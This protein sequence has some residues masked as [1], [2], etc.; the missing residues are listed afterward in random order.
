LAQRSRFDEGA[1]CEGIAMNR[2]CW[3]VLSVMVASV[4]TTCPTAVAVPP[5]QKMMPFKRIDA[6]PKK[7]YTLTADNGPWLIMAATFSGDKAR[8][9]A[10][11]LVY[12]LRSRYKLPAFTYEVIFDYTQSTE[13]RGVNRYGAPQKGKYAL[14]KKIDEFAVLAGEF[15][16]VDDPSAQKTLEKLKRAPID[17]MDLNKRQSEGKK[18]YRSLGY[19]RSVIDDAAAKA[20]SKKGDAA[21][22]RGPLARAFITSNPLM[23]KGYF[24]PQGLDKFVLALNEDFEFSLLKCPA[25]YTVKVA[26]FNGRVEIDQKKIKELMNGKDMK[27][28]LEQAAVMAHKLTLALRKKGFEAYEFH[29]RFSSIV[30]VG[31][32]DS[33]GT[34]R[35]DGKT[36]I[37]PA[38]Y[39]LILSFGADKQNLPGQPPGVGQAKTFDGVPC[40]SQPMMVHVPHRSI[41]ADYDRAKFSLR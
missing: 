38:A 31:S 29:D 9:Q 17:C 10:Q 41:S 12:E 26:T 34:P 37:N 28:Q 14:K 19:V 20:K 32:F 27:S 36:E 40:D 30:T 39:K 18:D 24:A 11:E 21:A 3:I 33:V 23:P 25:K 8:E 5:W 16:A 7:S 35:A 4:W 15:S 1:G 13:F 6:D 2:S 22:E